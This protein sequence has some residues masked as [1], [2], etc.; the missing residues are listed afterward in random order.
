MAGEDREEPGPDIVRV[1]TD[2]QQESAAAGRRANADDRGWRARSRRVLRCLSHHAGLLTALATIALVS[3]GWLQWQTLQ[4]TDTTQRVLQRAWISIPTITF[5][6]RVAAQSGDYLDP[7]PT[8]DGDK[9]GFRLRFFLRNVGHTPAFDV[10]V[11]ARVYLET[12]HK[13]G[14]KEPQKEVCAH[15]RAELVRG[16]PNARYTILP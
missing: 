3:V 11:A 12:G 13:D 14:W 5:Q 4:N 8:Y 7:W 9:V 6:P 10:R 15:L 1:P 16:E 2:N